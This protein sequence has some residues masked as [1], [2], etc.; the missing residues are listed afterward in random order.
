MLRESILRPL[1]VLIATAK[2]THCYPV[3]LALNMRIE[4]T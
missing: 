3:P 2:L 1:K 4:K